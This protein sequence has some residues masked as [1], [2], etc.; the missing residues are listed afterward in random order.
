MTSGNVW[1]VLDA[2]RLPKRPLPVR[3]TL[4]KEKIE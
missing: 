4:V 1:H 2:E 3:R